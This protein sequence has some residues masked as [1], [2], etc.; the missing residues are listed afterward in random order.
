[1]Q[2]EGTKGGLDG[3]TNN[4]NALANSWNAASWRWTA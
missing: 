4:V 2:I 1:V 3:Y